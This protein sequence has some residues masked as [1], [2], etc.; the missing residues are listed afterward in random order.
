[1]NKLTSF[2]FRVTAPLMVATV[3]LFLGGCVTA[4]KNTEALDNLRSKLTQLQSDP[5]LAT[6][7]PVAIDEAE[8]A[9]RIAEQPQDDEALA[10]HLLY[11]ADH[12]VDI[13][14][15]RAQK[16]LLEDQRKV[17]SVER[18]TARLEASKRQAATARNEADKAREEEKLARLQ[19]MAAKQASTAAEQEA[20]AARNAKAMAE[21][22]SAFAAQRN[23]ELQ[24]QIDTLNARETERGLIVTLGDLLFDTGKADL[25][26]GTTSNLNKLVTFLTK[27]PESTVILEGYTDSAGSDT[28]N[29]GL[30]HNRAESVRNYLEQHSIAA[31]RLTAAGKGEASPV[32]SNDTASGRR[33][34]R[35]VDVIIS[36]PLTTR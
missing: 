4:P 23:A 19:E 13:A 36:N 5:Q 22:D 28:Y 3:V 29:L 27:Y 7:A 10:A 32:A 15:L 30:S 1:M 17:L 6:R 31:S 9:V 8:Q 33:Q 25:K 20:Q 26:E 35:R 2:K 34:N 18:E 11:L 24:Q 16:R 14:S 12:K 21:Q